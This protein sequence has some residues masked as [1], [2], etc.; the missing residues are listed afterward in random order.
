ML[1]RDI[2]SIL[3][4]CRTYHI[5]LWKRLILIYIDFVCILI[6]RWSFQSGSAALKNKNYFARLAFSGVLSGLDEKAFVTLPVDKFIMGYD[7]T[8]YEFSKNLNQFTNRSTPDKFGLFA[9]VSN[10]TLICKYRDSEFSNSLFFF[11][12]RVCNL[13]ST[14]LTLALRT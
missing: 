2:F 11:R 6:L 8:L 4:S 9:F 13:A 12:N 7:D 5:K 10:V 14:Q 3:G 1:D